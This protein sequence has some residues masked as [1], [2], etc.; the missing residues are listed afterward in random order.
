MGRFGAVSAVLAAVLTT[1]SIPC[2]AAAAAAQRFPVIAQIPAGNAFWDYAAVVPQDHRLYVSRENGVTAVDTRTQKAIVR[3]APGKQVHAFVPLSGGRALITNGAADTAVILR[4]SDGK[5]LATI[6]TGHKPD[7]AGFD[8]ATGLVLVCDGISHDILFIDPRTAKVVGRIAVEG[9]P[10]SPVFDGA[11]H[12]FL[13][14]ADKSEIA[15]IDTRAKTI[16]KRYPLP[17]CGDASG[18]GLDQASGVILSTCNDFKAVATDSKSGRILGTVPIAKYPDAMITD[19]ARHRFYVPCIIPGVLV[20]VGLGP[21]R[22]PRVIAKAT[23]A[24]GVH[25]GALDPTSGRLYLPAGL[26]QIPKTPGARPTVAPGTFKILVV[27]V[28]R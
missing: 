13:N 19:Q 6:A 17:D 28:T 16:L 9:E 8:P 18:I 10:E 25:T 14:I 4:R 22:A 15:V 1:L 26:I 3:L 20:V 23:M 7:G 24:P 12:A 11:G 5:T 21:D 2:P 27:D